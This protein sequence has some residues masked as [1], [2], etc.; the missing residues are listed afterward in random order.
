MKPLRDL[1]FRRQI[2]LLGSKQKLLENKKI[3]IVGA[4]GLGNT[5][6]TIISCI[7]LEKI[8]IIDFDKIEIHN[9]HRQIQFTE[10]DLGKNKAKVLGEKI[11]RCNT[12][13]EIVE[14]KFSSDMNFDIDLVFD[15]TDNFEAR[16]EIDKFSKKNSVPWIY[17]SVDEYYAQVGFFKKTDFNTFATKKLSP[18]G[19]IPP[20]VSLAASIEAMMGVKYLIG[21]IKEEILYYIDFS[22]D[23]EIKKFKF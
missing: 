18:K 4:G 20:M 7:G 11:K 10:N 1:M 14:N 17:T 12:K 22:K 6:A 13:I 23:L 8:I 9:I 16:E 5:L 21:E 2:E 3:L 15:A 19:Q